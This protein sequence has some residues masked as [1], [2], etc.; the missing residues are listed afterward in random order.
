MKKILIYASA[1][2]GGIIAT[3]FALLVYS[4]SF[5]QNAVIQ[6]VTKQY[7]HASRLVIF[8]NMAIGFISDSSVQ[9]KNLENLPHMLKVIPTGTIAQIYLNPFERIYVPPQYLGVY[10]INASGHEGF[11]VLQVKDGVLYG[12]VRFPNWANGVWEPLKGVTIKNNTLQFTRSVTT[13]QE[14]IKTGA[15]EYFTQYYVGTYKENGNKLIG[16]YKSRGAKYLFEAYR[17]K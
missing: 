12:S 4:V 9:N 14:R 10:R 2:I 16:F 13:E 5:T 8:G 11:L 3:L 6:D 1:F 17:K 7:Y 15:R